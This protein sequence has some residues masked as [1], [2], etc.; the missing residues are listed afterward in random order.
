[1]I[2]D[3]AVL[4][5]GDKA[6]GFTLESDAGARVSLSDFAGKTL[7]LYFYPKD[8]TPGCT[9]QAQAFSAARWAIEKAGGVVVGV[10]KDSVKSHCSFRDKYELTI[11]LLSDPD[12]AVHEAY[13]AWGEKTMYGKKVQGT[14]RSTFLI[15]DGV[16]VR[17]YPSVKVDGHADQILA[18]LGELSGGSAKT[19]PPTAT[20]KTKDAAPR[21]AKAPAAKRTGRTAKSTAKTTAKTAKKARANATSTARKTTPKKPAKKLTKAPAA[22]AKAKANTAKAAKTP[23]TTK[24]PARKATAGR[25]AKPGRRAPRT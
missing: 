2:Y 14:I 12:L 13:G 17:V 6:P 1:M 15:K 22:G 18:A 23:A 25:K 11:P 19:M 7:V 24:K 3:D 21:M 4:K 5:Q 8:S 16:V 9:R 20:R 10:S